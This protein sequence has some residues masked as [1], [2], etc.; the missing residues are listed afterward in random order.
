MHC[1]Q[2]SFRSITSA[3]ASRRSGSMAGVAAGCCALAVPPLPSASS[4][5]TSVASATATRRGRGTE[6]LT[7]PPPALRR[8][9][10]AP[11]CA[12]RRSL[13][14]AT[15]RS[16][17]RSCRRPRRSR[18][19]PSADSRTT[20]TSRH[21]LVVP[22]LNEGVQV[23]ARAS[24]RRST[25]AVGCSAKFVKKRRP[26][27]SVVTRLAVP[28]HVEGDEHLALDAVA[29]CPGARAGLDRSGCSP[30]GFERL[31][32][33]DGSRAPAPGRSSSR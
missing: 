30:T 26:G 29:P 22:A 27:S 23:I 25:I 32:G 17:H 33:C 31:A 28:V 14:T 10:R 20:W 21:P 2:S 7:I 13:A 18:A 24:V 19:T 3:C 16:A 6:R 15:A 8:R 11:R 12:P 9:A 4:A 5:R 1:G